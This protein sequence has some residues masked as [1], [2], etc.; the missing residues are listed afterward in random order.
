MTGPS[1]SVAI[2]WLTLFL[3]LSSIFCFWVLLDPLRGIPGPLNARFSRLWMV[4]HSRN[5]QMH[6]TMIALHRKHGRLVRTGPNEI[7]VSDLAAV[8]TMYAAG[9][10]FKKSEW[11]GVWQ[12]HRAFDLFA[13][14][15]ERKHGLQR[16]LVSNIY[17]MES[18]LESEKYIDRCLKIF[19]SK[20]SQR[21]SQPIDLG[22]W[23]Q[24]FAFGE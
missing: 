23:L 15:N 21:V 2:F 19:L 3:V 24:L 8:K 17:S 20:L 16:R 7:S 10:R 14:R 12:G 9:S 11:Y 1:T 18:L 6:R 22:L 13:E 5:G 4:K